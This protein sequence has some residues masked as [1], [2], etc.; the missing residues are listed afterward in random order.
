MQHKHRHL[1]SPQPHYGL[2][3]LVGV[4]VI[5][6]GLVSLAFVNVPAPQN[7]VVVE[8]DAKTLSESK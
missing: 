3:A 5:L 4:A 6:A 8:L 2:F 1:G 7:A